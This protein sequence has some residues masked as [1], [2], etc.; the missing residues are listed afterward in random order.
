LDNFHGDAPVARPVAVEES[1]NPHRIAA[2]RSYLDEHPLRASLRNRVA[3]AEVSETG[4][5][6]ITGERL[7]DPK[8]EANG[9]DTGIV[10]HGTE[11]PSG[12]IHSPVP[13]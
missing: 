9:G 10:N 6:T 5:I 8:E 1:D 3:R 4:E 12:R 11:W 7:G 2:G 13:S